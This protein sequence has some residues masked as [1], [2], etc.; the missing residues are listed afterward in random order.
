MLD[1]QICILSGDDGLQV[2]DVDV[3]EKGR[4]ERYRTI[5]LWVPQWLLWLRDHQLLVL[6]SGSLQF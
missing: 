4:Q 6:F 1:R 2:R 3:E 5:A